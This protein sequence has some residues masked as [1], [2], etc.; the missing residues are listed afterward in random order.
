MLYCHICET[1]HI[2]RLIDAQSRGDGLLCCCGE[3]VTPCRNMIPCPHIDI[4]EFDDNYTERNYVFL[5]DEA[6]A[7]LENAAIQA[8]TDKK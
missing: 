1:D 6:Y 8:I 4:C 5:T 7:M 3:F 2:P